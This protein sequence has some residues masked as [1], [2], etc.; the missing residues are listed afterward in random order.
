M[1]TISWTITGGKGHIFSTV[2]TSKLAGKTC[3]NLE[4]FCEDVLSLEAHK[5][6]NRMKQD[7]TVFEVI[8]KVLEEVLEEVIEEDVVDTVDTVFVVLCLQPW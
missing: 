2:H 4:V 5:M 8:N 7:E 6:D 1:I 3:T